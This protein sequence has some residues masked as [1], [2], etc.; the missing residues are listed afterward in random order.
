LFV[1]SE[2]TLGI[3]TEITLKLY[4]VPESILSATCA[5]KDIEG[6]ANSKFFKLSKFFP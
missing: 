2:G 5:F 6:A 3:V 1:G 4:G